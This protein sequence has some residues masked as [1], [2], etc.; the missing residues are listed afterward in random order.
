MKLISF[1]VTQFRSVEDSGWINTNDVTA[2][3]GTNESGKTNL[4]VPLW[5]LNPAKDGEINP[6]QDY[7]RDKY[8][9][10]RAQKKKPVFI[11]ARFQLSDELSGTISAITRLPREQ[12]N[13]VIVK[14]DFD[15]E[16]YVGFPEA[17]GPTEPKT[18]TIRDLIVQTIQNINEIPTTIKADEPLKESILH[19]LSTALT[20]LEGIT[21]P[22]IGL[23][24]LTQIKTIFNE[25]DLTKAARRSSISPRFGQLI[26]EIDEFIE[27]VNIPE[28]TDNE[29][30]INLILDNL[31]TFVYYSNYGNL[32][33]EIYL[34]HVIQN[35]NRSD[36]GVKEAAKARTLKV[37]F[38]FVKLKP[39]EILDLGQ[40]FPQG[41]SPTQE[42]IEAVA[43]KKKERDVLLQSASTELTSRFREWWK[44][45]DYRF[46]FQAD[47]N[48]FRIW[49]S[50]DK[51]PE[52][53]ELESR[54]TGLQ[55]FLSF[56]LV[57]LVESQ[58]SHKGAILLLDEPGHS[59]HPI[60]QRDLF[61]FFDNLSKTN[62]ILYTTHSPFM[63]DPN[64][65]DRVKAVYIDSTGSTAV[66]ANLRAAEG[67]IKQTQSIYPVHAALGLSVSDTLLQGCISVIVEGT[68]DQYYL[69]AIKNFLIGKGLILPN[70][71]IVFIPAGGVKG[72]T[73]VVSII[74]G[75]EQTLPFVLLD[76]DAQ[77]LS[78]AKKLKEGIFE[79]SPN[80]VIV[81]NDYVELENAEIEDFIPLDFLANVVTRMLPRPAD[82]EEE[83]IDVVRPGIPIVQQI[84]AYVS[85]N[86]I[87]LQKGWKVELAQRTKTQLLRE[88]A[89]KQIDESTIGVWV[90]LFQ[91]ILGVNNE[92]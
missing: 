91:C 87:E 44:Q 2:F 26:D 41:S 79:S 7:P 48:H 62:Q 36:L 56:Y 16:Y 73:A 90:K 83:F 23:T 46:R 14:R 12:I 85:S 49:V 5:K 22:S 37:L 76:G 78:G 43:E 86:N 57:F 72:I 1:R 66:S 39:Q 15:G 32:D 24:V 4:L 19:V 69:S 3:I 38:N 6:I 54:S 65:L 30:V 20:L 71:E 92:A 42:Q 10:I 88:R 21:E 89:S 27:A 8:H 59:L 51:R 9:I 52:D 77:G 80:N 25:I 33:S 82:L 53:I 61:A 18:Q 11:Q 28:P 55:W 17:K 84:E 31:P 34:P 13:Q 81:V 47:G 74:T 75:R 45:G 67:Q 60:A 40:D 64:H 29:E 70:R 58:S 63:V 68:S 50:D 35:M